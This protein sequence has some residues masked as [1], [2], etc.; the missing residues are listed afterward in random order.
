MKVAV[1]VAVT[2]VMFVSACVYAQ[3]SLSG[4]YTGYFVANTRVGTQA[5]GLTLV[6]DSV[7][8]GAV[9]GTATNY[10]KVC[11]GDFPMEG[12]LQGDKLELRSIAKGGPAGD[13]S[14]EWSL[15]VEGNKLVG[16]GRGGNAITLSR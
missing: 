12:K 10:A 1:A 4:R 13:C 11:R 2:G 3:E 6:I 8:D 15:N 7:V 16:T 9:K 5:V 14:L